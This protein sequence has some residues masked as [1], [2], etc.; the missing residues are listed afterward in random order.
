MIE[1]VTV[2]TLHVCDETPYPTCAP[3]LH[4]HGDPVELLSLN[5]F[6]SLLQIDMQDIYTYNSNL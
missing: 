2:N 4:V 1:L 5:I 3:N 6:I